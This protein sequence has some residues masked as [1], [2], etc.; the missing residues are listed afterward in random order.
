MNGR[1]RVNKGSNNFKYL[2]KKSTK[3]KKFYNYI[4]NYNFY[5]KL[6]K[7]LNDNFKNDK[8]E[9]NNNIVRYSKKLWFTKRKQV[10]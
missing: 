2:L 5:K 1:F 10:Y 9:L 6:N 3:I 8:W 7:L 4:N